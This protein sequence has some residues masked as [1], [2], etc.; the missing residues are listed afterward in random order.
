M[1]DFRS[2][3]V[4]QP[5][6][7][8][9]QAMSQAP[10]GDDV[11]G[12]DPTINH[13]QSSAAEILG[14]PAALFCASGTQANLLALMSHC[15][16]GDEYICGLKAH[17]FV[18]E[19][20]GAA[21]L[22]SIQPQPVVNQADGTLA[23]KDIEEAIKPDDIH[24]ARTK[25][26]SLENTF[27]GQVLPLDYLPKVRQ[28]CD[29]YQLGLHLD[30]ARLFNAAVKQQV[31]IRQITEHLDT[32]TVCLSKGLAAPIGSLLLGP[33]DF[34]DRAT[35]LRKVLGGGWRQAGIIAAAAQIAL[36]KMPQRLIHDHELAVYL[37]Q[38][39]EEINE[40]RVDR[41]LV[42]TNMVYVD[43]LDGRG[44]ELE[45]FLHDRGILL[46][47][48]KTI[49]FVTHLDVDQNSVDQLITAIKAFY[50]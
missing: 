14:A 47:G 26:V 37:A 31:D 27:H 36:E 19:Q 41:T 44:R 13:L 9:R 34:I 45:A 24:F 4:T 1:L 43:C 42:Q 33:R 38:R 25:V 20:G 3:T 29:Q 28:L 5:T 15:G 49:R 12:N 11:Y 35:R 18:Y 40:F 48:D 30:G 8:M 22:G 10:V 32:F 16:R 50:R 7:E 6:P 39:L 21:T 23:L 46:F 2:D 17:N